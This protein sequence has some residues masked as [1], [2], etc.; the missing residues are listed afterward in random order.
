MGEYLVWREAQDFSPATINNDGTALRFLARVLGD[1]R[2]LRDIDH[3]D[4]MHVIGIALEGRKP[5]SVNAYHACFSAFFRWCRVMR[6]MGIDHDPMLG[7]RYRRVQKT[8]RRKIPVHDFPAFLDVAPDARHRMFSSLGLYL[9]L[10]ASEAV[11]LRWRDVD[12]DAGTIGVT[13]FKTNDYDLM[14]ISKELDQEIRTWMLY[15]QSELDGPIRGD[16][17]LVPTIRCLGPSHWILN[18]EGKI[19]RPHD[20]VK[21]HLNAYG[22]EDT[23]WQGMHCLRA[24]GAR[25]WFDELVAH[26]TDGAL[27]LVQTH[28]H[29]SSVVMTERYLGLSADRVKRDRTLKGSAMFPSLGSTGNVLRISRA[30]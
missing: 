22:W 16:W 25:A 29:H 26:G 5:Q 27:K 21:R 30:G 11:N 15:L 12:L 14:P 3:N 20:L 1:H 18:P 8:E 19:S 6:Y 2:L 13:I 10:R 23:H 28:L 4:M 17:Y 9:F 7:I 24:S